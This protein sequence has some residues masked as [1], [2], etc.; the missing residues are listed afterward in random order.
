MRDRQPRSAPFS[1][2]S[3][4]RKARP[5]VV[6]GWHR[7]SRS[8]RVDLEASGSRSA[9]A[10]GGHLGYA[11]EF[12]RP[13]LDTSTEDA[14]MT[15]PNLTAWF[16][17][18]GSLDTDLQF[19]EFFFADHTVMFRCMRQYQN[20]GPGPVVA[21]TAGTYFVGQGDFR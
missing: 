19:S 20:A 11:I 1:A 14:A 8:P 3:S 15:T 13:T 2:R 12:R 21:A 7:D 18:Q 4:N 9:H 17:W 6:L 10:S 16:G 5:Q